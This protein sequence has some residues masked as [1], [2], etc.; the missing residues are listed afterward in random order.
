[1]GSGKSTVGPL[2]AR[3]LGWDFYDL[4][5]RIEEIIGMPIAAY[6]KQEGEPAFRAVERE[7]LHESESVS[8]TVIAVGGG[9]LCNPDNLN[10]AKAHGT[11]IYLSVSIGSIVK[12]LKAE[13]TTR[14]MLLGKDGQLLEDETVTDRIASL[15]KGRL[16]LYDQSDL[17]IETDG[18]SP[19]HIAKRLAIQLNKQ[20]ETRNPKP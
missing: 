3:A 8:Q 1:M 5:D 6:F 10:W 20:P 12:R 19:K 18:L 14:P 15:L 11:V 17:I 9:A 4:D 16:P 2:L 13:Q 7:A